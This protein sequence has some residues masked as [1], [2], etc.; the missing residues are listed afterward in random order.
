[1]SVFL[2]ILL[3]FS[4]TTRI[5]DNDLLKRQENTLSQINDNFPIV[6]HREGTSCLLALSVFGKHV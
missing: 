1:M 6:L 3:I 5:K 4:S 2:V